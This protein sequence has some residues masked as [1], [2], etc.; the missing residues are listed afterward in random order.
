MAGMAGMATMASLLSVTGTQDHGNRTTL[1]ET[2][3]RQVRRAVLQKCRMSSSQQVQH[4]NEFWSTSASSGCVWSDFITGQP[5]AGQQAIN[6][7]YSL[8]I[9]Q[10]K[11]VGDEPRIL[12]RCRQIQMKPLGSTAVGPPAE[13]AGYMICDRV[14]IQEVEIV[15]M[16]P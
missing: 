6:I 12:S 9:F 15:A 10:I 11:W 2:S 4:P 8:S 3:F 7:H 16:N 5:V 13:C 1:R 14:K